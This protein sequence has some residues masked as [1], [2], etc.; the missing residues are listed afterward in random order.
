[1][2]LTIFDFESDLSCQVGILKKIGHMFV[3]EL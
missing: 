2:A 3:F 1:M